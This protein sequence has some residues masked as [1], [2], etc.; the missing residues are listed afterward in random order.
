MEG[1]IRSTVETAG[2]RTK[3]CSIF[4]RALP[5]FRCTELDA[6]ILRPQERHTRSH[7]SPNISEWRNEAAAQIAQL[8]TRPAGVLV[9]QAVTEMVA[10]KRKMRREV[11]AMRRYKDSAVKLGKALVF[12]S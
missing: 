2:G 5:S 11:V 1:E 6:V 9:L 12:G 3:E 8:G 7:E 10:V 4:S